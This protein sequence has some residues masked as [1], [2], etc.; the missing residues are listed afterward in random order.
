MKKT[1]VLPLVYLLV[2]TA[3]ARADQAQAPGLK[4]VM[5]LI[6]ANL[7]GVS[8]R[9]I[10]DAAIS[11]LARELQPR[12]VIEAATNT[13]AA[14]GAAFPFRNFGG[15]GYARITR[16]EPGLDLRLS[17]AVKAFA[18]T[19]T[20]KGIILDLRFAQGDDY[21]AASAVASLFISQE[22]PLLT[23][24]G[25]SSKSASNPAAFT[26]PLA[27]L[28]N[29]ETSGAAEALGA[30]L[31]DTRSG[32][33]IGHRT[34]GQAVV[35]KKFSLGNGRQL[36]IAGPPVGITDKGLIDPQG[37]VPDI[38]IE[39]PIS[40]D[41]LFYADPYRVAP[42]NP[43]NRPAISSASVDEDDLAASGH[44]LN[45]AE[46]VRMRRE[47]LNPV[48]GGVSEEAAGRARSETDF[49]RDKKGGAVVP[50][51]PHPRV[52]TDPTLNRALDLLKAL[53]VVRSKPA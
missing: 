2:L 18:A 49:I 35:Y 47:G 3:A 42:S 8:E 22:R 10:E 32:L 52:L 28:V 21:S 16:V 30:L 43:S 33:I 46:L 53:S 29:R 11:G 9:Q 4:E 15:V 20:L 41:R 45:E 51:A 34:A 13:P 25:G 7:P 39:V 37:L 44:R 48:D 17:Q 14:E 31:R 40:E 19:N 5:E 1:V 38:A 12:V 36:K 23:W 24:E 6:R 50:E 26:L 27:V